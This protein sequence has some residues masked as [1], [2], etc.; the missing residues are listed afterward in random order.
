M[1]STR[2][3]GTRQLRNQEDRIK[4]RRERPCDGH[5]WRQGLGCLL[6]KGGPPTHVCAGP[7]QSEHPWANIQGIRANAA[8]QV[9]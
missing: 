8:C 4:C 2:R 7:C 5:T 9:D 3:P 6:I 1:Q